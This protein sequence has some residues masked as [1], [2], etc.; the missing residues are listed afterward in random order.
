MFAVQQHAIGE[1]NEVVFR[2]PKTDPYWS[3]PRRFCLYPYPGNDEHDVW[4][5]LR[6]RRPDHT[7]E[8]IRI[9]KSRNTDGYAIYAYAADGG[10]EITNW[11]LLPDLLML[12]VVAYFLEH[13]KY[14]SIYVET[15]DIGTDHTEESS[16]ATDVSALHTVGYSYDASSVGDHSASSQATRS[17]SAG[18]RRSRNQDGSEG[19]ERPSYALAVHRNQL[20]PVTVVSIQDQQRK[21]FIDNGIAIPPADKFLSTLHGR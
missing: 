2:Y 20:D 5:A 9:L 21:F 16:A 1:D 11:A 14:N 10:A 19:G 7:D 6:R 4:A 17:T 3:Q 13:P 8:L 15:V 18:S 12:D